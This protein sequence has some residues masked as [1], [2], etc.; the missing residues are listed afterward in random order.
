MI[1]CK[2]EQLRLTKQVAATQIKY[3]QTYQELRKRSVFQA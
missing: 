2:E 1:F 3:S